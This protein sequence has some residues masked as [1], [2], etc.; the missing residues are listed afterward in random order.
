MNLAILSAVTAFCAEAAYLA[1][2]APVAAQTAIPAA[3]QAGAEQTREV[4]QA[5]APAETAAAGPGSDRDEAALRQFDDDG[6]EGALAFS[7]LSDDEIAARLVDYLETSK[8]LQ[9]DFTQV[10]PSG[11]VSTGRFYVRRPGLLRFEYDD[12]N[13]L[14][15]VANGGV[16]YVRDDALETTDSYPLGRTPLKFLLSKKVD[17]SDAEIVGVDRGVD[18]AAV[19]FASSDDETEGELTVIMAAPEIALRRWIVRDRQ[20]GVTVVSLENVREGDAI[21]S[22]LF[23]A[24][25]AGGS[26]LKN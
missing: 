22:R 23:R 9:G 26:F 24:P 4:K 19:T 17:L 14:L 16:V 3:A 18:N 12:P 15:I 10:A 5:E 21:A 25:D 2:I 11:A 20:N 13:P 6:F 1:P 8:T 7:D